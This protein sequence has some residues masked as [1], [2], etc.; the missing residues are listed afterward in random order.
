MTELERSYVHG[1][2][3]AS[4]IGEP[5]G[6][7][8]DR[9]AASRP[10]G[11]ALVARHQGVRWT[12][13]TLRERVDAFAAGLLDTGLTPGDRVAIWVQNRAEW[14]VAQFATAKAGLI[15]VNIN[16]AARTGELQE[17]LNTV[18]AR[19]L[20]LQDSFKSSD[21]IAMIRELAP[22]LS[23]SAPGRLQCRAVPS[24]EV[25]IRLGEG[26]TDGMLHF[27]DVLGRAADAARER[28][29]EI[30]REIRFD[31]PV[32]IQFSSAT[33][34]R[35][36]GATLTHHN[37]LNNG[38]F[39]GGTLRLGESDRICIPVPLFHCFGMVMG[40]MACLA[41]GA[42]MVYPEDAFDPE[43]TLAAIA[44]ERC[45]ACYGVPAMFIGMLEHERFDDYDLSSLRTG[46]MGG[47][48]CP[49]ETMQQVVRDMHMQE[50]TIAY[51]M[52]ETSPVSFMC[53]IDDSIERR[54]ST[55]GTVRPYVEAKIIDARGRIVP[56]DTPGELCIR[57]YNVMRG[58]WE[59]PDYT[60]RVIDRAGWMHTGDLAKLDAAG[61][62]NIVGEVKDTIIRGGENVSPSEVESFLAGHDAVA[63]AIV[64]GV[65]DRR[66]GE[67]LCACVRL[68]PG[69]ALDADDLR[70]FCRDRIAHY[71][72]P[73]YV[74]TYQAFPDSSGRAL[75]YLLRE[76]S[77][78]DLGLAE[79]ETT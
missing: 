31:D 66:M 68:E 50:V 47:A 9:T 19:A 8:F 38:Y 36:A 49:I 63:E 67:E 69:H 23:G 55:V 62:C 54:V 28:L 65:P 6:R 56:V 13:R 11:D 46:V 44:E 22:E 45:T 40:N 30:G 64:V 78:A 24:L 3:T 35:P 4:L 42:T 74:R 76:E 14:T 60:D 71:K 21:Y 25:V 27:D 61:Y 77:L 53:D 32:N 58:Y 79:A 51:G 41:H 26:R 43:A 5:I 73:R 10:D 52:T 57:G 70:A 37:I 1:V 72:I 15:L 59:D 20:I 12:W 18:G 17:Q 75:R 29:D 33:G 7:F 2:G 48:P 16:P 39:I 34:E